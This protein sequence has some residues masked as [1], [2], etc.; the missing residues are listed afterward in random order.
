MPLS[1]FNIY[2]AL[3][4][5]SG[6]WEATVCSFFKLVVLVLWPLEGGITIHKHRSDILLVYEIETANSHISTH[7]K[8][9]GHSLFTP[10]S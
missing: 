1:V 7:L 4:L 6:W 9:S 10:V 5:N 8:S 3:E 2:L